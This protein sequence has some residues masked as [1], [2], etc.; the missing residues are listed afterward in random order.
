MRNDTFKRIVCFVLAAIMTLSLCSPGLVTSYATQDTETP[1]T[2][3]QPTGES[4]TE[5]TVETTETQTETETETE[6]AEPIDISEVKQSQ[7]DVAETA[8]TDASND[9][10]S[11]NENTFTAKIIHPRGGTVTFDAYDSM[12]KEES[13]AN[14]TE[15]GDVKATVLNAAPGDEVKLNL[16]ALKYY[17]VDSIQIIDQE[18]EDVLADDK[19][20]DDS[21]SF[22]MPDKNVRIMAHFAIDV[23]GKHVIKE[24]LDV[25]DW[26]IT[27]GDSDE[28]VNSMPDYLVAR[29]DDDE[30][31]SVPCDWE[32]IDTKDD[33]TNLT[34]TMRLVLPDNYSLA[35]GLDIPTEDIVAYN[36]YGTSV[37]SGSKVTNNNDGT[38]T[39]TSDGNNK[40][41]IRAY[42]QGSYTFKSLPDKESNYIYYWNEWSS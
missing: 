7:K 23:S 22:V 12:S 11:G 40:T 34:L 9:D 33:G 6:A 18:T 42:K 20:K 30:V 21:Y 31:D 10:K 39:I 29:F 19:V 2:E 38:Y 35:D 28:L 13:M 16:S 17:K 41:T 26:F 14:S 3:G 27:T 4:N 37:A 24:F 25:Q 36:F 5:E 32:I 8:E 1:N 15:G